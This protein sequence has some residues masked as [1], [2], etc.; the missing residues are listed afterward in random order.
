[1]CKNIELLLICGLNKS[2]KKNIGKR[3]FDELDSD[4]KFIDLNLGPK[5]NKM[6]TEG[7]EACMV[8]LRALAAISM[9]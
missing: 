4:S 6:V 7:P 3:I 1:M 9:M 2:K 5:N 8:Y